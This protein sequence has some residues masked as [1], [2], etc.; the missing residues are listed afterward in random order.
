[1]VCIHILT[2]YFV[3]NNMF[4]YL[5]FLY[6]VL[7]VYMY[8]VLVLCLNVGEKRCIQYFDML[9]LLSSSIEHMLQNVFKHEVRLRSAYT[10]PLRL[11]V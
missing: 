2:Y 3:Y 11:C 4:V 1:M 10:S 7:Y 6:V 8:I 9:V 5:C